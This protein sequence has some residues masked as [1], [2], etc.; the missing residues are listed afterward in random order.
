MIW[1]YWL[2]GLSLSVAVSILVIQKDREFGYVFLAVLASAFVLIS[3]MLT[4]RLMSLDLFGY[5]SVLVTGSLIWP[6]IGQISDMINEV[7][8]K[9]KTLVV[10][11]FAYLT[12]FL[13]VIFVG[14][15]CDTVPV[16][17]EQE[18]F[19]WHKYF[20][21]SL[22]VFIASSIS[23]FFCQFLDASVFSFFKEKSRSHEN[24]NRIGNMALFGTLRSVMSDI[25]NMIFDAVV[26][27][28][29]A[30]VGQLPKDELF[31][32]I[33]GSAFIKI[34]LSVIDTPFFVIYRIGIKNVIRDK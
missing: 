8:G 19:L 15:A 2:L 24:D 25:I 1:L 17:S 13:F 21:P 18:E 10:F 16:W 26:F 27:S 5:S 6:F 11:T 34:V 32:L 3:N 22:R 23:F 33:A 31:A 28:V 4:P 9:K 30:F 20:T 12:N 14:M 7:Y 29:V